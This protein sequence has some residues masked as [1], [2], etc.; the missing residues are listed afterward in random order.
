MDTISPNTP[1]LLNRNLSSLT[2]KEL[3]WRYGLISSIEKD[4]NFCNNEY[5]VQDISA[6]NAKFVYISAYPFFYND[7]RNELYDNEKI[8]EELSEKFDNSKCLSNL[9]TGS[10]VKIYEIN[11]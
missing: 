1:T 10:R 9:Y 5:I 3:A 4:P 11:K 2:T 7:P 6:Y 8:F